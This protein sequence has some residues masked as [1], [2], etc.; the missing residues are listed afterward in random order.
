MPKVFCYGNN[1]NHNILVIEL[2]GKSLEELFNQ[3][4]RKFTLKTVSVI[5]IEMI[6]RIQFV[7]DKN[8]IHR[9]IKPDNFMMGIN[10]DE[11][12]LYIIDFGLAKKF[13]S[14]TKKGHIPFKSNKNI[15]GTARYCSV[16][17]HKGYEQSRREDLESIAN[18]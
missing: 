5:G 10:S 16:N 4:A 1:K 14:S 6:K 15:T 8:H 18:L 13:R 11:D 2:L 17:T 12:K 7:H 3:C 9:D